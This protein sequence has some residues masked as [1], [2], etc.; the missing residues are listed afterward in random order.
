MLSVFVPK[1]KSIGADS[2]TC[3]G[4]TFLTNLRCCGKT[5]ICCIGYSKIFDKVYLNTLSFDS[6]SCKAYSILI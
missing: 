2:C 3:L 1:G 5:L 6:I 4:N